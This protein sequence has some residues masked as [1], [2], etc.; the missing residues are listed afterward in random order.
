MTDL[1][2]DRGNDRTLTI[3]A[4]SSLEGVT[5]RF[6]ASRRRG[7][8]VLLEVEGTG[9]SEGIATIDLMGSDTAILPAPAVLAWDLEGVAVDETRHT[10]A[11]GRL[12]VR[13]VVIVSPVGGS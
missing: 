9:D 3:D 8:T 2:I 5:L 10:L 13:D 12:Y 11:R 1:A 4:G 7:G 6:A